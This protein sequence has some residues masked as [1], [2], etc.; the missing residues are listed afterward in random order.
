MTMLPE[1]NEA[2]AAS[3]AC[4]RMLDIHSA[5]AADHGKIV[6]LWHQGWHEAHA[7]LVPPEVL[8]FRTEDHFATWLKE[9]NDTFYVATDGT[10]CLGFVSVKAAEVVKLYVGRPARGTGAAH[11][12][13]SFAEKLLSASGVTQAELLCTAGNS[14]AETFYLREGWR[15]TDTYQEALWMPKGVNRQ[16]IVPTHRFQKA[17]SPAT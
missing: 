1:T 13:L 16:F 15:L 3:A 8:S 2:R 7:A 5:K 17:L 14:R 10:Q 9:A 11:A 6:Q 12:L 4:D